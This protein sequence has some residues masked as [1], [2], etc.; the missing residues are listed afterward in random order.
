MKV[1]LSTLALLLPLAA[2]A[3]AQDFE[4][5]A[6]AYERGDY[7]AAL[8]EWRPLAQRGMAQAQARLGL[9]YHKGRS[10][11]QDNAE[12]VKW[13][14]KA[15]EQGHTKAQARLGLMYAMALGV[16]ENNTEAVKWLREGAKKN[17]AEAQVLLGLMY[18]GGLGIAQD[19]VQAHKWFNLSGAQGNKEAIKARDELAERM[20]PEQI[21]EAQKL[22]RQWMEEHGDAP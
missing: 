13:F 7:A 16:P 12:A 2:P 1:M 15:A 11:P 5:G 8:D 3:V 4:K 19:Y 18:T 9:M 10:V 17:D 6:E 22:A 14:R 20:T 21:A